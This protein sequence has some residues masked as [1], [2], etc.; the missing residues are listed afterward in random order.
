MARKYY[1]P[2]SSRLQPTAAWHNT[3]PWHASVSCVQAA[4]GP[5][6]QPWP[7]NVRD[8]PSQ[9]SGYYEGRESGKMIATL[10]TGL[11]LFA[12]LFGINSCVHSY[13]IVR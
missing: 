4:T 5:E 3:Q 9:S 1:L 8:P 13:L 6:P 10:I 7:A 2:L 12:F 11:V